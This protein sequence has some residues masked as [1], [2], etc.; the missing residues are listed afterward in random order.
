M[1]NGIAM[2][3]T[4]RDSDNSASMLE[5]IPVVLPHQLCTIRWRDIGKLIQQ[6]QARLKMHMDLK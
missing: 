1:I 4:L 5:E 3:K 6:F 2:A